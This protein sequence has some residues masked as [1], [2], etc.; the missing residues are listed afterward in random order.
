MVH[1]IVQLTLL[2]T[3]S[4]LCEVKFTGVQLKAQWK[5]GVPRHVPAPEPLF[6]CF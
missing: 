6:A 3:E 2:V 5:M 4:E 1:Q